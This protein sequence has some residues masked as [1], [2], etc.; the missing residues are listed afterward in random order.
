[1][2]T[3]ALLG[4]TLGLGFVSGLRL[5]STVLTVG[6]GVRFGLIHLDPALYPLHVLTHPMILTVAAAIYIVEFFAD[7]IP[8]I[9]S[10]WDSLHTFIRPLG[11][12]LIGATAIGAVDPLAKM[13]VMLL[14]GGVALSGH[15]MKAGTRILV[16]HSPEPFTNIGLSLFEDAFVVGGTW[17][18][19]AHPVFMFAAVVVFLIIFTFLSPKIFRLL[20]V[21]ING[22][23]AFLEKFLSPPPATD[24]RSALIE[25]MPEKYHDYWQ[26]KGLPADLQCRI[27]CVAGKGVK[28][29]RHSMGYF[30]LAENQ[31]FFITRRSF[32]FR[33]HQVDLRQ[34]VEYYFKSKLLFDQLILQ[35]AVKQQYFYFFKDS[36]NRGEVVFNKLQH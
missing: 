15:S 2:D 30:C 4:S 10:L 28:G 1:M 5:Y 8:W 18:S 23:F 13:T 9:D 25:A 22:F 19:V 16:N 20:R 31:A 32:R 7:K 34:V 11:A 6:L 3:I 17:L 35:E 24:V 29:L 26:K 21:E 36:L 33:L 27:L 12:A 14:C